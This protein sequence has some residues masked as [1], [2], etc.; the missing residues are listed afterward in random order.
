MTAAVFRRARALTLLAWMGLLLLVLAWHAVGVPAAPG[1]VILSVV[2]L[3]LLAPLPGL[4]AGRRRT[5][6]WAPLTLAP[7]LAW[8]LTEILANPPARRFAVAAS[9]L[10][11]LSLAAVVAAL[12]SMPARS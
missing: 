7:A 11:F 5:Y 6:R 4:W 10:A 8:S 3:P 12:R 1:P 9:L 2:T